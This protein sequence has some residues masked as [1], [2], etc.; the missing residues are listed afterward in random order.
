MLQNDV[1]GFAKTLGKKTGNATAIF[2]NDSGQ[3]FQI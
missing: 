2:F 1:T 3:V